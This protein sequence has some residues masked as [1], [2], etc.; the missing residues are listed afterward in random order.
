MRTISTIIITPWQ[1]LTDLKGEWLANGIESNT[2]FTSID[3]SD[4]WFDFDEKAK[5]EVSIKDVKWEIR[6]A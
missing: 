1:P 4:E 6:R 5:E 3:L 2:Q